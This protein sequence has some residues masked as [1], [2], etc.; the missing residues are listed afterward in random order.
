MNDLFKSW[1]FE[2]DNS[3]PPEIEDPGEDSEIGDSGPPDIVDDNPPPD[4]SMDDMG[5]D[6]FGDS[7]FGDEEQSEE[8]PEDNLNNLELDEKISAIM[9]NKLYQRYLSMI[10]SIGSHISQIT[11]NND[12]MFSL[13]G[14]GYD[15]LLDKFKKLDENIKLWMKNNFINENY[16]KNLLFFNMC[17]NLLNLLNDSL[18]D[19]IKKAIK[20]KE[21][22]E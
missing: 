9:N 8:N 3:D 6:E 22:P 13:L 10:N 15:E 20:D 11:D 12:I 14:D 1:I 7:E 2:E 19:K 4:M 18:E 17:L 16:S 5:D 21:D